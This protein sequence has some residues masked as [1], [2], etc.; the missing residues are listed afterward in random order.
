MHSINLI[1]FC[2]IFFLCN[3]ATQQEQRPTYNF[4]GILPTRSRSHYKV[5]NALMLALAK[6]GHNVTVISP[7]R[8]DQQ[9]RELVG[10]NYNF[11][12]LEPIGDDNEQ[13]SIESNLYAYEE[14]GLLQ[15]MYAIE[16]LM[17]LSKRITNDT[18]HSNVFRRFLTVDAPQRHFDAIIMEIFLN[19]AMLGLAANHFGGAP[20]IGYSTIGP[21]K[22]TDEI[23]QVAT[24]DAPPYAHPLLSYAEPLTFAQRL[25]TMAVRMCESISFRNRYI[26]MHQ[27]MYDRAFAD[28]KPEFNAVRSNV[29]LILLN[30]HFSMATPRPHEPTMIQAAGWHLNGDDRRQ[31]LPR[32]I[33]HFLDQAHDGGVIFFSMGSIVRA[34]Q[35]RPEHVQAIV[36]AFDRFRHQRILWKW[37]GTKEAVPSRDRSRYMFVDWLPQEDVLAHP[38]VRLFITHGGLLSMIEAVWHRVPMVAIPIC[39]DQPMN[40][41][42]AVRDGYAQRL[43]VSNLTAN[44][45]AWAIGKVLNGA[46]YTVAVRIVSDR[47]RDRM[48]SPTETVVYWVEYVAKHRGAAHMRRMSIAADEQRWHC[49]WN[50]IVGMLAL[51]IVCAAVNRR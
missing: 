27:Q 33:Q 24:D 10:A 25:I 13:Q 34:N 23:L 36:S 29:S 45:L 46:E 26:P 44:S 37:D 21:T 14:D 31:P 35:W 2:A 3:A 28:P 42:R 49:W 1:H 50:V 16:S 51:L 12:Q 40:V 11:I 8:P 39:C 18:L 22:S 15:P 7:Y 30:S 17:R 41:A 5:G 9:R 47:F 43:T 48:V 6:A 19:E 38:N 4:L 32:G 20:I